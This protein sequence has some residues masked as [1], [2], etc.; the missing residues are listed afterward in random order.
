MGWA[1]LEDEFK[2]QCSIPHEH[3]VDVG[4]LELMRM[5]IIIT[6]KGAIQ[7]FL[8]SPHWP[9]HNHMQIPCNTLSA[10]HT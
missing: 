5:I 2:S 1:V 7:V 8:Q 3:Y 10:P 6:S 4:K 9:G